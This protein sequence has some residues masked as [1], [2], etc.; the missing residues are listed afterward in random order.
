M[1]IYNQF[2]AVYIIYFI[3]NDNVI[4]CVRNAKNF[5]LVLTKLYNIKCIYQTTYRVLNFNYF[6]LR[7]VMEILKKKKKQSGNFE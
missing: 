5:N 1:C 4:C 3:R 6:Y 7:D 2:F